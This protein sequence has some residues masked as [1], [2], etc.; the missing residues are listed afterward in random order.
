[1]DI[2]GR[3]QDAL[4]I[5]YHLRECKL[6]LDGEPLEFAVAA[7]RKVYK[8]RANVTRREQVKLSGLNRTVWAYKVEPQAEYTGDSKPKGDM[9]LWLEEET[10]V[11][12]KIVIDVPVIT[13]MSLTLM[14]AENSPLNE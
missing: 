14:R 7:S 1:M 8:I 12:V 3:V 6:S 4:S 2:P 5:V 13:S 10:N 9:V 11:P